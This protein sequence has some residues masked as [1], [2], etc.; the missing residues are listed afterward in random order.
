MKQSFKDFFT[1]GPITQKQEDLFLEVTGV[2]LCDDIQTF[3]AWLVLKRHLNPNIKLD[4][5]TKPKSIFEL[6]STTQIKC[7]VKALPN[8]S[9]LAQEFNMRWGNRPN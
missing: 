7:L 3:I 8:L 6:R 4:E 5:N 9:S 1:N 2:K